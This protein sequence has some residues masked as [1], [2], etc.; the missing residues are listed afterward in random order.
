MTARPSVEARPL[1]DLTKKIK[2]KIAL[3]HVERRAGTVSWTGKAKLTT[4]YRI[5]ID[6]T[7][8]HGYLTIEIENGFRGGWACSGDG[9]TRVMTDSYPK[10]PLRVHKVVVRAPA[11][12]A[13]AVLI[14]RM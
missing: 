7:G 14:A 2:G 13:W 4:D 12:A 1:V 9:H 8:S 11:D 10:G 5:G 3:H 6:C